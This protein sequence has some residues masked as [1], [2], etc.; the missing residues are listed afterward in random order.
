MS[1][2]WICIFFYSCSWCRVCI[3]FFFSLFNNI[4]IIISLSSVLFECVFFFR[5][6][7]YNR[8]FNKFMGINIF[9]CS[10]LCYFSNV[11]FF[12]FKKWCL[13]FLI[14]LIFLMFNF[15]GIFNF[16]FIVWLFCLIGIFILYLLYDLGLFLLG[17]SVICVLVYLKN[18]IF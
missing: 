5:I 15:F 9:I 8:K 13:K 10:S 18:L 12:I 6:S 11:F 2:I 17:L 16:I 3:I 4:F 7:Y 14:G 1:V